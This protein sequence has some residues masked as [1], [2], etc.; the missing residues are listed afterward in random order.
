M[1][2]GDAVCFNQHERSRNFWDNMLGFALFLA[3]V[4]FCFYTYPLRGA[5]AGEPVPAEKPPPAD[6]IELPLDSLYYSS[7]KDGHVSL[8][9]IADSE[10]GATWSHYAELSGITVEMRTDKQE[11][12][13]VRMHG[14]HEG[15]YQYYGKLIILVPVEE[16]VATWQKEIEKYREMRGSYLKE[17][18]RLPRRVL[19]RPS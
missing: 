17:R 3:W 19:P 7:P 9:T 18:R 13:S 10:T 4:S 5:V 14:K 6:A 15:K 2:L 11:Y 1:M 8:S 12:T 16:D